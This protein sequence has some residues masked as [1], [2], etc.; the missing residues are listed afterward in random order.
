MLFQ[1]LRHQIQ[2]EPPTISSTVRR[3]NENGQ[4]DI[5]AYLRLEVTGDLSC[6]SANPVIKVKAGHGITA[7]K[8]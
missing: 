8:A 7:R 5:G 1:F 2:R 3:A 6:R 4:K